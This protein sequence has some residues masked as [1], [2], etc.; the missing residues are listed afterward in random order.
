MDGK[1]NDFL[2]RL[3]EKVSKIEEKLSQRME[4]CYQ[5]FSRID[6]LENKVKNMEEVYKQL[7]NWLIILIANIILNL[8]SMAIGFKTNGVFEKLFK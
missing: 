6:V 1:L 5:K 2:L 8:V 4:I 7:R 3:D